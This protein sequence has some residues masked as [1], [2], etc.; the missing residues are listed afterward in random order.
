MKTN[1]I[2]IGTQAYWMKIPRVLSYDKMGITHSIDKR[3][4]LLIWRIL[5][6][7]LS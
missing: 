5:L 4:N 2:T 3:F 6:D 7:V 1:K